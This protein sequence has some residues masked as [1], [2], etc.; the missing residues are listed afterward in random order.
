[1][2]WTESEEGAFGDQQTSK[3]VTLSVPPLSSA[4]DYCLPKAGI[5]KSEYPRGILPL[6][7][8]SVTLV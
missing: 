3:F 8:S 1:M 2:L 5:Y 4:Y 6:G 7:F